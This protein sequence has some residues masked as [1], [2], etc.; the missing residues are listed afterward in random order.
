[1]GTYIIDS[2]TFATIGYDPTNC[3]QSTTLRGADLS[4]DIGWI[5]SEVTIGG[6]NKM[7]DAKWIPLLSIA[8]PAAQ[9]I[10]TNI[11]SS[12]SNPQVSFIKG[13]CYTYACYSELHVY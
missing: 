5:D 10:T 9:N 4:V 1:M 11:P 12:A 2:I 6:K 3:L 8:A 7:E 13:K